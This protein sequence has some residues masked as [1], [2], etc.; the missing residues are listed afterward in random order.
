MSRAQTTFTLLIS[1][2]AKEA[3][4]HNAIDCRQVCPSR[5]RFTNT[6]VDFLRA[7]SD[8]RKAC[9]PAWPSHPAQ[10]RGGNHVSVGL[11]LRCFGIAMTYSHR[12]LPHAALLSWTQT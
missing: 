12:D 7:T 3:H 6:F 11:H 2:S 8:R 10:A 5:A 9:D 4:A 1:S